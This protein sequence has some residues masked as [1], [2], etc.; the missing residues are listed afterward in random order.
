MHMA[1]QLAPDIEAS[2]RQ[3]LENG[4]FRNENEVVREA[5]HLLELREYQ[6]QRL[7]AS[8]LESFAAVD[9]GEGVELTNELWDILIEEADEDARRGIAPDPDVCP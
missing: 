3:R 1:I 4:N 5:M 8:V 2:I 9:R 7:Q 6:R